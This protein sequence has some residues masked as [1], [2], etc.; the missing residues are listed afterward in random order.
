MTIVDRLRERFWF[1]PALLCLAA[2]VLAEGLVVIDE[3]VGVGDVPGWV[4]AVLYRVG[5]SGSR[6]ILGAIATSSLAVAGTT[7]SITMAVLA[8]TSSSYGPRLVRN[9]MADRGNQTV[10]GVYVSTFLYS[11]LVLR[12]IR[13]IGDPGDPEADVFVPHL[14]VN[15]AVVLALANVAVLVY[16]IHHITDSIQV[17]TLAREVRDDLA[18]VVDRM[19]PADVGRDA[20]ADRG[21]AA[22][23]GAVDDAADDDPADGDAATPRLRAG[24]PEHPD[25]QGFAV[26]TEVTGYVHHVRDD[27]LMAAACDAD[28]LLVLRTRPGRYV[29]AGDVIAVVHPSAR[30]HD[31]VV[32]GVRQAVS[33]ADERSP[34]QDVEFAIQQLTEMAV[35]ALSPGTN[36]PYTAVN[37][38]HDLAAGLTALASRDLPSPDR[39]GPDGALR[40]HAPR[41][42][43][44]E[45]ISTVVDHMRWYAASSPTVMHATLDLV[46]QVTAHARTAE[47]RDRMA[48]QVGLLRDAFQG[49]G[50][51]DHDTRRYDEHAVRVLRA[52]RPG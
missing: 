27:D 49:A 14:A 34:V 3:H 31:E 24:L 17:S 1:V 39:V 52:V 11:V 40:V 46:E 37:A 51:H 41:P 9:F 2:L 29:C 21:A 15:A 45:L 42:D 44:V 16:F 32:A 25:A 6:D 5:E 30:A 12:S 26:T 28:V 35:R 8:L 13:A 18:L 4:R 10:L 36:D 50:H 47:L 43:P 20:R 38:L 33:V 7:F 23:D 48:V 19:Y 22:D